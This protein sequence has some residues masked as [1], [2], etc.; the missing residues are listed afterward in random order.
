MPIAHAI[1]SSTPTTRVHRNAPDLD[2]SF[3]ARG[4]G[5]IQRRIFSLSLE[6]PL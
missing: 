2:V 1:F 5:L 4:A 6:I 3:L